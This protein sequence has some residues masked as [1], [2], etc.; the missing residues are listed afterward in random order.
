[1]WYKARVTS[2]YSLSILLYTF[3]SILFSYGCY[4]FLFYDEFLSSLYHLRISSSVSPLGVRFCRWS[5]YFCPYYPCLLLLSIDHR[6]YHLRISSSVSPLGVL[7]CLSS[8]APFVMIYVLT[9]R[10]SLFSM[11]LYGCFLFSFFW[12]ILYCDLFSRHLQV[13]SILN[14]RVS[15]SSM[16]YHSISSIY[17]YLYLYNMYIYTCIQDCPHA[18][19]FYLFFKII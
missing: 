7:Y 8:Y 12:S 13:F 17:L 10:C 15:L 14:R 5:F 18:L 6:M 19:A 4:Q 2:R 9:S 1:M 16:L 11:L 3:I